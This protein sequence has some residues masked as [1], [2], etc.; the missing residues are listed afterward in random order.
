MKDGTKNNTRLN[1]VVPYLA[2]IFL[3]GNL[4]V[5]FTGFLKVPVT[6]LLLAFDAAKLYP[7]H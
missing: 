7:D 5:L 2:F 3:T 1:G 6:V 4:K